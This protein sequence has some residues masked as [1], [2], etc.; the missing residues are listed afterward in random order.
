MFFYHEFIYVIEKKEIFMKE[1]QV[2]K[3]RK[4]KITSDSEVQTLEIGKDIIDSG[5]LNKLT[6]ASLSIFIYLATH[7]TQEKFIELDLSLLSKKIPYNI[8]DIKNG[9]EILNNQNLIKLTNQDN[10]QLIYKIEFK[11]EVKPSQ[12]EN[13]INPPD[14]RL[15]YRKDI[16]N[17][18]NISNKQLIKALLSFVPPEKNPNSFKNEI[19]KWIKDF[20][21][22]LL[23][24]LIRRVDKWLSKHDNSSEAEGFYYLKGII[25]DWYKKEIYSYKK[26][27]YFDRLFRETRELGKSYGIKWRNISPA[28]LET[29]KDWLTKDF[30]LSKSVVKYAIR[31][32]T[33]RKSNG[34]PSLKYIEDNFIKPWKQAGVKS[35]KEAKR[36]L[37]SK[38][39]KENNKPKK[40]NSYENTFKKDWDKF[41]WDLN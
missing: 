18:N 7:I 4:V 22:S 28:Q 41:Y 12:Q 17:I 30:A 19:D 23:Q 35:I 3:E 6:D 2:K 13:N 24:E 31:E 15:T 20:E 5:F 14:D 38:N 8:N 9:L 25:N 33:K 1:I 10:K 26:L 40:E 36:Y 16:I 39:K 34:Q 29:F 37:T 32:A 27:K 11:P 21:P